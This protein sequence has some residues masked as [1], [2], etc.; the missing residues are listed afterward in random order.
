MRL[1]VPTGVGTTANVGVIVTVE[2]PAAK[3]ATVGDTTFSAGIS[4]LQLIETSRASVVSPERVR[5]NRGALVMTCGPS[6]QPCEATPGSVPVT[7]TDAAVC[8]TPGPV[9]TV[10]AHKLVASAVPNRRRLIGGC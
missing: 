1:N 10:T 9:Q 8:A 2:D 5:T 4:P 3:C 6:A 7:E